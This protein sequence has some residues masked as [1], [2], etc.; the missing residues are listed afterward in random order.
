MPTPFPAG[1]HGAYQIVGA[2]AP[3][4]RPVVVPE[5]SDLKQLVEQIAGRIGRALERRGLVE[6]DL[7]NAWLAADTEAGPLDDLLGHSITYRIA[8]GPRAGQKLFTLQTVAP[9]LQGLE[10]EPNG[11]ARAGGFSLHAGVDIALVRSLPTGGISKACGALHHTQSMARSQCSR[12]RQTRNLESFNASSAARAISSGT[13]N[14]SKSERV[15]RLSIAAN[16][17][18]RGADCPLPAVF[19][20]RVQRLSRFHKPS[21][22]WIRDSVSCP[23]PSCS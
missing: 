15:Q 9:R 17:R 20:Q 13:V 16:T 4:F 7:E 18:N 19:D 12:V 14:R 5:S 6:R 23:M 21:L 3:M 22:L 10:A 2:A 11:A 1:S 8:V